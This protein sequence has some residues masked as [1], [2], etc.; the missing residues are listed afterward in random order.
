MVQFIIFLFDSRSFKYDSTLDSN[1]DAIRTNYSD[2]NFSFKSYVTRNSGSKEYQARG[3]F[4]RT[5]YRKHSK[6]LVDTLQNWESQLEFTSYEYKEGLFTPE[7]IEPEFVEYM[8]QMKKHL[9]KAYQGLL[10]FTLDIEINRKDL[11]TRI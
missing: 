2:N 10:L 7:R 8:Q 3:Q 4:F 11:C 1:K 5:H 9:D 6:Q